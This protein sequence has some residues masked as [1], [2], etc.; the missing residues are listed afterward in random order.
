MPTIKEVA[1]QTK[2]LID[3]LHDVA[4]EQQKQIKELTAANQA[5]GETGIASAR[6]EADDATA[7]L[8]AL[9]KSKQVAVAHATDQGKQVKSLGLE[10]D[11]LRADNKALNAKLEAIKAASS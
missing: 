3:R 10:N 11:Q 2:G 4:V 5:I 1:D 9:R 7:E 8:K 6:K